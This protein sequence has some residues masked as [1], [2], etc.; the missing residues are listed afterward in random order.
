MCLYK[1]GARDSWLKSW[2]HWGEGM[3][4]PRALLKIL[5]FGTTFFFAKDPPIGEAPCTW[6]HGVLPLVS[7]LKA[8]TLPWL[9]KASRSVPVLDALLPPGPPKMPI[10]R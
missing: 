6:V 3:Y 9:P 5:G 7:I 1:F 8:L 2:E 4:C 10:S